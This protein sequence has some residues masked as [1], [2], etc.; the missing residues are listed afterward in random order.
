[1]MVLVRKYYI[2]DA[3]NYFP[4]MIVNLRKRKYALDPR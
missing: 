4:K 2:F 1:M 3:G